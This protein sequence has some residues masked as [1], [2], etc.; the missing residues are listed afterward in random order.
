[1]DGVAAG[2]PGQSCA[3]SEQSSDFRFDGVSSV[4]TAATPAAPRRHR[5]LIVTVFTP[6]MVV[7]GIIARRSTNGMTRVERSRSFPR[8][9]SNRGTSSLANHSVQITM[10]PSGGPSQCLLVIVG[11]GD[12]RTLVSWSALGSIGPT[13]RSA[14]SFLSGRRETQ[15]NQKA[16][17]PR[18]NLQVGRRPRRPSR[19]HGCRRNFPEKCCGPGD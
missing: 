14:L 8:S 12:A 10:G 9:R 15:R 4:Q 1:M 13:R 11:S 6:R 19:G 18:I 5:V 7:G 16:R 2:D 3:V 17:P